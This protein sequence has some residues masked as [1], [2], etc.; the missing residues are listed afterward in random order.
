MP[1]IHLVFRTA[2]KHERQRDIQDFADFEQ[3]YC[4][5]AV[6]TFFIILNLLKR[7][8]QCFCKPFLADVARKP[9]LAHSRANVF[10][11]C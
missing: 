11:N 6:D 1:H 8:T 5:D 9:T 4:T 3:A 7:D 10:V 2:L